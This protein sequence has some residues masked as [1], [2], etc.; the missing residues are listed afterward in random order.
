MLCRECPNEI[1]DGSLRKLRLES[2]ISKL[3]KAGRLMNYV[4]VESYLGDGLRLRDCDFCQR[5]VIL[6]L[7]R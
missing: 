2:V 4:G 7:S 5:K 6:S 3:V 1:A